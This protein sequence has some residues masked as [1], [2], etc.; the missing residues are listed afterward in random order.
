MKE[1]TKNIIDEVIAIMRNNG[2]ECYTIELLLQC[3]SNDSIAVFTI[4]FDY[5]TYDEQTI[6]IGNLEDVEK[7]NSS[8]PCIWLTSLLELDYRILYCS[9]SFH[10]LLWMIYS[11][12]FE[13]FEIH[14]NGLNE[15]LR[16]C[17]QHHISLELLKQ[18]SGRTF[19]DVPVMEFKKT[20]LYTVIDHFSINGQAFLFLANETDGTF[21]VYD[22]DVDYSCY[23]NKKIF[24]SY[25][26]AFNDFQERIISTYVG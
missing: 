1:K 24:D 14:K 22:S 16:Y 20:G 19:K 7:I 26:E 23:K 9:L 2:L 25:L 6:Y 15:Y 18:Y 5:K 3:E 4:C 11:E 13:S 8:N 21:G 10:C 17:K 12:Y